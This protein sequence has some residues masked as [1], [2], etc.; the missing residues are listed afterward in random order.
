MRARGR[1]NGLYSNGAEYTPWWV[2]LRTGTFV[3][4][5]LCTGCRTHQWWQ[6]DRQKGN[7]R[8]LWHGYTYTCIHRFSN[9]YHVYLFVCTVERCPHG[10]DSSTLAANDDDVWH[11]CSLSFFSKSSVCA[12]S[13]SS[14]SST[15]N[16]S[17]TCYCPQSVSFSPLH[18]G[19]NSI[20]CAG[21][22][23]GTTGYTMSCI[24]LSPSGPSP[25]R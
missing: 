22:N 20:R 5:T 11:T 10:G 8:Q 4:R 19:A 3:C 2:V 24:Y 15:H 13:P 7:V 14:W 18:Q 9:M 16:G 6:F 12:P 25:K 17:P 23:A 1:Y 21:R